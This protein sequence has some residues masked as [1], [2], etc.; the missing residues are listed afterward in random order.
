M[1][2]F[3]EEKANKRSISKRKAVF[4]VGINDSTYNIQQI[5]NKKVLTCPYYR[6]WHGMLLRCYSKPFQ[7]KQQTYVGCY[8]SDDWLLF[9]NFKSWMAGQD[10]QDMDLDK[11]FKVKDNKVYSKDTCLFI[12]RKLNLL[13][14][15]NKTSNNPYPTG[16]NLITES[17]MFR[18]KIYED[19]KIRHLGCFN[20]AKEASNRYQNARAS[21]IQRL[22][23]NN[24]YPVA[25]KYLKQHILTTKGE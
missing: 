8:V 24:T 23:D 7:K 14:T 6:R 11:D 17:G 1:N 4:G 25:T 10:W 22:I 2:T 5:I 16:V 18:A 21:K 15:D 19:G 20:T 12:P 9:S 13:L 3:K